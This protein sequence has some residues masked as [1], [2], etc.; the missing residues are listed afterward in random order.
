MNKTDYEAIKTKQQSMWA[1][2]NYSRISTAL[3][4]NQ[5]AESGI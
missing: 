3:T 1:S 4:F 2:G 5:Q